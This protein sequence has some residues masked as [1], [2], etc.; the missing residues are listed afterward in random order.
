MFAV[1]ALVAVIGCHQYVIDGRVTMHG[2][3]QEKDGRQLLVPYTLGQE[4]VTLLQMPQQIVFQ[5]DEALS[6]QA[7]DGQ[8]RP[9]SHGPG[10]KDAKGGRQAWKKGVRPMVNDASQY[11]GRDGKTDLVGRMFRFLT[12][13]QGNGWGTDAGGQ[14]VVR[15]GQPVDGENGRQTGRTPQNGQPYHHEPR[16]GRRRHGNSSWLCCM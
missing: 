5:R 14:V 10:R 7:Q 13:Q 3:A 9:Q 12:A 15:P 16:N 4:L 8:V 11:Q 6:H 2:G 1:A